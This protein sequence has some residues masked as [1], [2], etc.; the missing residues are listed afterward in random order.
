MLVET[1]AIIAHCLL[2]FRAAVN[3]RRR[4]VHL[5]SSCYCMVHELSVRCY[6]RVDVCVKIGVDCQWGCFRDGDGHGNT[7]G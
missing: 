4:M 1:G 3:V 7:H 2:A 5:L 6:A